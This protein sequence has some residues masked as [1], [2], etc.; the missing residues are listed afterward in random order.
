MEMQQEE[1]VI[2][3]IFNKN[4]D[5]KNVVLQGQGYGLIEACSTPMYNSLPSLLEA[6]GSLE[7]QSLENPFFINNQEND[8]KS[9]ISPL[10]SQSHVGC[11]VNALNP[12]FL[13]ITTTSTINNN[14]CRTITSNNQSQSMLFKSFLSHQ[15]CDFKEQSTV[16][17]QC[18]T[19]ANFSHF[20]LHADANYFNLSWVDKFHLNSHQ[21]PMFFEMDC[22]VSGFSAAA[23]GTVA[24]DASTSTA[25]NRADFQ[26][27]L[28]PLI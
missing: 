6:P 17:K 26:M 10:V 1:W 2:C 4:E 11:S 3:R 27:M 23:N 20:Q 8:F 13:P 28:D 22:N 16:S 25:F 18:K 15:D 7:C 21:N 5:K 9:L 14:T 12:S 19:E 24:Y